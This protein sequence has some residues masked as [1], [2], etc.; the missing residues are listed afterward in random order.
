[1]GTEVDLTEVDSTEVDS[2]EVD[3]TQVDSTEV[4]STEVDSTAVDST[5]VHN[6]K[7]VNTE[8]ERCVSNSQ[9]DKISSQ[10][11]V[12]FTYQGWHYDECLRQADFTPGSPL[13]W[14]ILGGE[15]KF[16]GPCLDPLKDSEDAK[17]GKVH[18]KEEL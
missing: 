12:P 16:C 13:K 6:T 4:D 9:G 18:Q 7:V 5:E 3:S 8:E 14:C 15:W 11:C 2:P 10:V 17:G 1:M